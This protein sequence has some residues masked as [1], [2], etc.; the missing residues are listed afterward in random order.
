MPESD[1]AALRSHQ[2]QPE[3]LLYISKFSRGCM[4]QDPPRIGVAMTYNYF[5]NIMSL[6]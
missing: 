6:A 1:T 4:P 3:K 5:H 2:K